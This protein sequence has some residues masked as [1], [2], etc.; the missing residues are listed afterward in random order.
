MLI[1]IC[2]FF[3]RL[4]VF[5]LITGSLIKGLRRVEG[6]LF[7]LPYCAKGCQKKIQVRDDG[8]LN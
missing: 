5:F 7:F 3:S 6:K 1:Y 2:L 4:S 8:G